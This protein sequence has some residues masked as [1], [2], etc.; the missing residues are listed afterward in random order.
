MATGTE[1]GMI[2]TPQ[3]VTVAQ[4]RHPWRTQQWWL[5]WSRPSLLHTT[6]NRTA[7]WDK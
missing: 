3:D 1:Q 5:Q 6:P 7:Q 4:Q 2:K